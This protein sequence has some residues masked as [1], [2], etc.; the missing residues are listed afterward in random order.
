MIDGRL[1]V[2]G[3]DVSTFRLRRLLNVTY[4]LLCEGKDENEI[5][6][7]DTQLEGEDSEAYVRQQVAATQQMAA[8]FGLAG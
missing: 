6:K 7:L 4:A 1:S 5:A 3:A 2:Q 8:Q